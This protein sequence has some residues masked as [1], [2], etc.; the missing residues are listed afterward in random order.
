MRIT[1]TL[2]EL[3][4]FGL[5]KNTRGILWNW[6]LHPTDRQGIAQAQTS[7]VV[8]QYLPL[9][10]YVKIADAS[11]TQHSELPPGVACIR[12]VVQ[13]WQLEA[14]GKA[15]IARKG[16][17]LACDFSGTAHSFMGATLTACA[18]DLGM[19][20]TTPSREAQLSGYMCLSRVKRCEDL[21]IAQPF[22]PN[23]FTNGDLIGPQTLLDFHRKQI[24]LEEAKARVERDAPKKKRH[25]D[26][27]LFCSP[28]GA[29]PDKL[30]PLREFV[31]VWDRDAWYKIVAQGM[32]RLCRQCAGS[33]DE[34][35]QPRQQD[36]S[37]LQC[38]RCRKQPA[39][40]TGYCAECFKKPLACAKCDIDK[41]TPPNTSLPLPSKKSD[42]AATPRN[43]GAPVAKSVP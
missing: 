24:T 8:L 38:A 34:P 14:H 10:L 29:K 33:N 42:G 30:L 23:L 41:K 11:W 4:P 2:P 16:F 20:D 17:P 18:L 26:I 5:F 27:M 13:Q 9:A 25:P 1:Q 22:S 43:C 7:D 39:D 15:T 19:W 37:T 36:P 3:K 6:T 28:Q 40:K 31:T 12:P 32:D 21:C 35:G